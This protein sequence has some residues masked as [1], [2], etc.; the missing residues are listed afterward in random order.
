MCYL[1]EGAETKT[2][3]W[4]PAAAFQGGLIKPFLSP[5]RVIILLRHIAIVPRDPRR[6]NRY[7]IRHHAGSKEAIAEKGYR[8]STAAPIAKQPRATWPRQ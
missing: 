4:A 6:I 8:S 2:C 3:A 7:G 5:K 1:Q